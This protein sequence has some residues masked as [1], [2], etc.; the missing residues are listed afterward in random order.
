MREFRHWAEKGGWAGDDGDPHAV[1]R[2]PEFRDMTT[3][4]VASPL[5]LDR[6]ISI[7]AA[8]PLI[9][10]ACPLLRELVNHGTLA[11]IRC[12]SIPQRKLDGRFAC[13]ALYRH[14]IEM[15]DGIEALISQCCAKPAVPTL[16]SSF[17]GLLSLA[18]I[19]ED[20]D[21]YS[22]R[23]DSWLVA[24]LRQW[25]SVYDLADQERGRG[26]ALF[27]VL[28]S[29]PT[30]QPIPPPPI[31]TEQARSKTG[32]FQRLLTEPPYQEIQEE[33]K[34][35]K[36]K[37]AQWYSLFG[38]P[39]NLQELAQ[40][41]RLLPEYEILYRQWSKTAHAQEHMDFFGPTSGGRSVLARLREPK[42]IPLTAFLAVTVIV[43][44]TTRTLRFFRPDE[45]FTA[46]HR[47]RV[48]PRQ[49]ALQ[50]ILDEVRKAKGVSSPA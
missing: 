49:D 41:L 42:D 22:Q 25:L 11:L 17:E 50:R 9:D 12:T 40:H 20:N 43:G 29:R 27:E 30:L 46:W 14:V 15:T 38:G 34:K 7:A 19:L 8:K 33:F 1:P 35:Q 18:Y 47:E 23:S 4:P 48:K 10:L 44:A 24:S 26:K 37:H 3:P 31:S 6:D 45:D 28:K 21:K 2:I 13:L 32:N 39:Q 16:R 36:K 5:V